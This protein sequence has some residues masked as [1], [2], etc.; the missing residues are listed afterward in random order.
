VNTAPQHD[1][2]EEID[3]TLRRAIRLEWL[4]LAY[5]TS[6]IVFL[7]L[8]LGNSQAMKAAW[9]E[10]LVGL[11]PPI[12][13]L[14]AERVRNREPNDRFP[15][16]YHRAVSIAYLTASLALLLLGAYVVVD[17]LIKLVTAEHPPIGVIEIFGETPWLGFLML[18][19]LAWS[20]IPAFFLG[21]AKLPLARDLHDK[22]LYAD[23]AMN[24][25][26][27]LTASAAAVGVVGIGFGLWWADA[28]AAAVIGSDVTRDGVKNVRRAVTDL[29]DS[30]P[31]RY[32]GI[33]P[34]PIQDQVEQA[35]CEMDW[36]EH[37]E[38]RMRE[39]GH[40]LT[41]EALVVPTTDEAL[42]AKVERAMLD[43]RKLDWRI[44][45]VVIVPVTDL[46]AEHGGST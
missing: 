6:A 4:T 12:A 13:F 24:R 10:D 38:L 20:A 34:H 44:Q 32:N 8:T 26:N 7:F 15:W 35:L 28:V 45:E 36:I 46:Q 9:L 43:L 42:P 27:W 19:A 2:P 39:E 29:M 21:R 17:A 33:E 1:L 3:A 25:A 16:G 14:I 41:G 31:T 11:L 23:A 5:M 30:R 18:P 40:V 22:V 37:V